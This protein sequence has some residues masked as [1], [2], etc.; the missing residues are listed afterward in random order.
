MKLPNIKILDEK[1]KRLHQ[2]S[3]EVEFPL[4]KKTKKLIDDIIN[5]FFIRSPSYFSR[6][7][8]YY[9]N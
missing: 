8:T 3:K 2:V 9:N 4:S 5:T 1:D 6:T 7:L